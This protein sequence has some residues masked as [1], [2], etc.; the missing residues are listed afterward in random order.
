ME[1]NSFGSTAG[2]DLVECLRFCKYVFGLHGV[3][4][5]L[6]SRRILGL[7]AIM[8][9]A[10]RVKNQAP[11][12]SL[13]QVQR[14]HD[15]LQSDPVI[16]NKVMAGSCLFAIYSRARWSDLRCIDHIVLNTKN[17][18]G[19]LEAFTREHKMSALGLRRE[20]YLPLIAPAQGVCHGDWT[21]EFRVAYE[22]A[23]LNLFAKPLGPLM[24]APDGRGGWCKRALTTEEAANWLRSFVQSLNPEVRVRSHSLKCTACVWSAQEGFDKETRAALSHHCSAVAGSEVVYSRELQVRPIRKL[25]M[26]FK[27]IRLGIQ[28]SAT[29]ES[30]GISKPEVV[31]VRP[32]DAVME[33][34]AANPVSPEYSP[35][36]APQPEFRP[37]A[38]KAEFPNLMEVESSG[39]EA[40]C[41][42]PFEFLGTNS[43]VEEAIHEEF[44][45]APEVVETGK[46]SLDSSSGSD[47]SSSETS[48]SSDQ[49]VAADLV[50]HTNI[51]F[52]ET[53]AEGMEYYK[54][55]KSKMLHSAKEG[56]AVFS[57]KRALNDKYVKMPHVIKFK[58]P[59]CIGCFKK[60][61]FRIRDVDQMANVLAE[62]A[63]KRSQSMAFGASKVQ[64][65]AK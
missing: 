23:G 4:D 49:E 26:L 6:Q 14:I 47:S 3:D 48:E 13:Q 19:T 22:Q 16:E 10:K 11:P 64:R 41:P 8:R 57:C 29:S 51:A 28:A 44:L 60:D 25:Q 56:S 42:E 12:L 54:H 38:V 50:Q 15:I 9:S 18:E 24:R 1:A 39:D 46:I 34:P 63:K 59:H 55:V 21:D 17:G 53:V 65:T 61:D 27:K 36:I 43:E 20:Q 45:F 33:V 30:A 52:Q 5:V 31:G 2:S 7:A 35:S 62:S 32:N 40:P 58:Y 37:V